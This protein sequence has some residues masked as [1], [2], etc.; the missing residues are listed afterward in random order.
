[1][2]PKSVEEE[3]EVKDSKIKLMNIYHNQIEHIP[4]IQ[5][6]NEKRRL[7]S[8]H[9]SVEEIQ[10]MNEKGAGEE[11]RIVKKSMRNG[12]KEELWQLKMK[13]NTLMMKGPRE[14]LLYNKIKPVRR[15][16]VGGRRG[17]RPPHFEIP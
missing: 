12:N 15:R 17:F 9:L 13:F 4:Q 11:L 2:P 6:M 8:A 3:Q 5:E 7:K 1:M 14:E 16:G 10:E